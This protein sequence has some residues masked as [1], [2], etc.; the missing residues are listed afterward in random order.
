MAKGVSLKGSNRG[1]GLLF[2]ICVCAV[3]SGW[4]AG[5]QEEG[6]SEDESPS[7]GPGSEPS[8]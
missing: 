2:Q 1:T 7:P 5:S 6:A 3:V 4:L 8:P